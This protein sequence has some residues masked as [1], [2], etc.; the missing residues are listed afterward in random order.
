[1]D[2]VRTEGTMDKSSRMQVFQG[3][4]DLEQQMHDHIHV[5]HGELTPLQARDKMVRNK[6]DQAPDTRMP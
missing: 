3:I 2:G 5:Q 6:R 1:M 4:G